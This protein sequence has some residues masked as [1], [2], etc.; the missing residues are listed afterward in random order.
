MRLVRC[1]FDTTHKQDI[2]WITK[3]ISFPGVDESRATQA[4]L[5]H[6]SFHPFLVPPPDRALPLTNFSKG[7]SLTKQRVI[8]Q[9]FRRHW[10]HHENKIT[11]QPS[12][13]LHHHLANFLLGPICSPFDLTPKPP[14]PKCHFSVTCRALES[15][16][17]SLL[18]CLLFS[19]NSREQHVPTHCKS[20]LD[21]L[22]EHLLKNKPET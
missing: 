21:H 20:M 11:L 17:S 5:P 13:I 16:V 18:A 2:S 3:Y 10:L 1:V 8:L 19:R 15:L 14:V 4:I 6:A 22:D 9:C 12:K 7:F